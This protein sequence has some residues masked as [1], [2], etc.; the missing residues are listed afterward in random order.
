MFVCVIKIYSRPYFKH[1]LV[2]YPFELNA[3]KFNIIS[4]HKDTLT[5]LNA[6]V[7]TCLSYKCH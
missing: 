1:S 4:A 5:S 6:K 2:Y 3:H 7:A